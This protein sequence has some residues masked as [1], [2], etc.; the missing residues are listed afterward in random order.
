MFFSLPS[1]YATGEYA[2]DSTFLQKPYSAHE[3]KCLGSLPRWLKHLWV[4]F[5]PPA[6]QVLGKDI[7]FL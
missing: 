6:L 7:E 1:Y 2:V 4:R 3:S 5:Q